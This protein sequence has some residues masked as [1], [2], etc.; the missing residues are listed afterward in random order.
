[1]KKSFKLVALMLM[2]V[3]GVSTGISY[4][5]KPKNDVSAYQNSDALSNVFVNE[6]W[7]GSGVD[8]DNLNIMF[9]YLTG[10]A[11]ATLSDVTALAN[12]NAN[13]GIIRSKT[14]SKGV[15]NSNTSYNEKS[16]GQGVV[17][18]LGGLDWQ[19]VYL[20][21]SK[22]GDTIATLYLANSYQQAF[23]DR[24]KN[25]GQH[26]GYV[27]G[28]LYSDYSYNIYSSDPT[29][30]NPTN[31]YG[32]SY[33]RAVTLNNGGSYLSNKNGTTLSVA[34]QD[35]DSA[36]S[37]FTMSDKTGNLTSILATPLEVSYQE[38]QSAIANG[39]KPW[40]SEYNLSNEAYSDAVS[41]DGFYYDESYGAY[42]NYAGKTL[43]GAWK[44]DYLWLPSLT[45][46]GYT[47]ENG[48]WG[49]NVTERSSSNGDYLNVSGVGTQN[50][51]GS[52]YCWLRSGACFNAFY[53]YPSG[54]NCGSC[55]VDNSC[56]VRPSLH[57]NLTSAAQA[58]KSS[59]TL[60]AQGVS[61]LSSGYL[62]ALSSNGYS[63]EEIATISFER[64]APVGYESIGDTANEASTQDMEI[65]VKTNAEDDSK[66]DI[67]F[68]SPYKM[69]FPTNST[70]LFKNLTSLK[71][72]YFNNI[73]D[74]SMVT[75]TTEMFAGCANLT[76]LNLSTLKFASL[77]TTTNMFNG[78][79]SLIAVKTPAQL[80][81]SITLAISLKDAQDAQVSVLSA[82]NTN[83]TLK[84][85]RDE[86][87]LYNDWDYV[88]GIDG[89]SV[90]SLTFASTVPAGYTEAN[91]TNVSSCYS[92]DD[93]AYG[94]I[95]AD[96][97]AQVEDVIC[98]YKQN[99][100]LVD[101]AIVSP[102][103][104]CLPTESY[105]IFNAAYDWQY[106]L[107]KIDVRNTSL[108]Y[109]TCLDEAFYGCFALEEII[110]EPT[111]DFSNVTDISYMFMQCNSLTSLD[112]SAWDVSGVENMSYMFNMA[113]WQDSEWT[114]E[115]QLA[116]LNLTGW[117]LS[118]LTSYDEM[119]V[120]CEKLIQIYTPAVMGD[121]EIDIS[122]T[123]E[124]EGLYV[125]GAGDAVT[126]LTSAQQ[127]TVLLQ[128]GASPVVPENPA[129]VDLIDILIMLVLTLTLSGVC[130][131]VLKN[132]NKKLTN[133]NVTIENAKKFI[134]KQ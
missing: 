5:L 81:A 91:S 10:N 25:E 40:G 90:K 6:L 11:N 12:S 58:A 96:W 107:E 113:D 84:Q 8:S 89:Y 38:T 118:S 121:V 49:L 94:T 132:K 26:Y 29:L 18:R 102:K 21:T 125:N 72:I 78:C 128:F 103:V 53:V 131:I 133:R 73:I 46:T 75:N 120:G 86:A 43:N 62:D 66:Y 48:I 111:W 112:L 34:S 114:Q 108:K 71:N 45:E 23:N 27:D 4:L 104:I 88:S 33:V 56:A 93:D 130:V 82:S 37:L 59:A 65:F 9:K 68:V 57:I 16:N 116:Y 24:A 63:A 15:Q 105:S 124:T 19:V 126:T 60:V 77:Q 117:D 47:G 39:I 127:N 67:A 44:N 54:F 51:G 36:F 55:S 106:Y 31:M 61:R 35:E 100:N 85:T 134:N 7:T 115:P 1:M 123:N 14:L 17:V 64:V 28:I 109:T 95:L 22:D 2:I 101:V 129:G 42:Y 32:A 87:F 122:M 20:T 76:S 41:N 79:S 99:G 119:F 3:F 98:Y 74:V 52:N 30:A 97:T 80:N 110:F 13:A 92:E 50:Q 70:G 69:E 83:Q